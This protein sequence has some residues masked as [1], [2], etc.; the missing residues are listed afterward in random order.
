MVD[1]PTKFDYKTDNLCL[2]FG[3]NEN[4]NILLVV[5]KKKKFHEYKNILSQ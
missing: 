3:F 5:K 1:F 2:G 4:Y